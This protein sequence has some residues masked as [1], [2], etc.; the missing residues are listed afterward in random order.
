MSVAIIKYNAGNVF[1]V[2][3]ALQRLGVEAVVTS[4]P[5]VLRAASH[6]VFPGVGQASAAMQSLRQSGLDR[7]I[8]A[9]TQPVLGICI[10]MQL[11][12]R[13]SEEGGT[14]GMGVFGVDVR[15]FNNECC[16]QLKI[17]HMGWNTL[18]V[19][20]N[21]LIDQALD[22]QYVYYVHSYY[23]PVCNATIATTSYIVPFSAALHS[24]NFWATQ[25][26]P[27]KSG[28]VGEAILKRFLEL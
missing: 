14:Q 17:P 3:C 24:G 9:L 20:P 7:V 23:A 8:P 6:V 4:D 11:L 12:C 26:H 16:P 2:R 10:G 22:G 13:S 27:E 18:A 21:E 25:F 1:S 5:A 28:S 15:R 19:Q